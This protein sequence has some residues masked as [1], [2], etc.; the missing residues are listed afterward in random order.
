MA[1]PLATCYGLPSYSKARA[2]RSPASDL[3]LKCTGAAAG[4]DATPKSGHRSS[5]WH[6][7]Q[8]QSWINIHDKCERLLNY[9]KTLAKGLELVGS[10][11]ERKQETPRFTCL[12]AERKG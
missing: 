1:W 9:T 3:R 8:R 5:M 12:G 10:K 4:S 2:L 6:A 11:A 7:M